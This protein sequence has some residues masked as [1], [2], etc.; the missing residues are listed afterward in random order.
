M[1]KR[2]KWLT[3][4][5]SLSALSLVAAAC[6]GDDDDGGGATGETS[7]EV[8]G[9]LNISGSSTVEP[10]TSLV[11]E[12]FIGQNP[13][14]DV[15]VDGPGT[16][17]GFELFCNGETDISDASRPIEEEE[18]TACEESGITPIEIEVAL[19]ALSVVVN[20]ANPMECVSLQDLY[21][22]LGPE[23]EGF[24][25]WSDADALATEVGGNGGFPDMP[26]TIVAPGEE[27]GTYGSFIDLVG[28]EDIALEQGVSEDAAGG[29]R[30][31][32]QI[33]A[34]DNVIIQNAADTEG[35]LGF[36]GFSFAEQAGD[37]VKELQVDG[38]EGC[39]EPSPET[40]IDGSYP[41]GRSLFIYV[42]ATKLEENPALGPFVDFY[43]S[44]EGIA[45]V[46]EVLYVPLPADRLEAARSAWETASA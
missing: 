26:L 18:V 38:G 17:D 11:A 41:L 29:L 9:S 8:T 45:S 31:D 4:V 28:T 42:N 44:D 33:S 10:I 15:A 5:A 46:E 7:E 20:P 40:V 27:S 14:V 36:V 13:G 34:D 16:S 2:R 24:G 21:A 23:S 22:L 35:G 37:S 25:T 30:P 3:L 43:L 19:D 1:G 32:Y 12:K 6:G 39:V